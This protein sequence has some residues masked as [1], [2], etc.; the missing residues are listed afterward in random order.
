MAKLTLGLWARRSL[1]RALGGLLGGLDG[2]RIQRIGCELSGAHPVGPEPLEPG[3]AR[4]EGPAEGDIDV[5]DVEHSVTEGDLIDGEVVAVE[6]GVRADRV[7]EVGRSRHPV[8]AGA[9]G[10]GVAAGIHAVEKVAAFGR[11]VNGID[12]GLE[13]LH[14]IAV[15]EV[16]VTELAGVKPAE[17]GGVAD[18]VF[19]LGEGTRRAPH[20]ERLDA[21]KD[22]GVDD[23]LGAGGADAVR[24]GG[25]E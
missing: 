23:D 5:A 11:H 13:D 7:V 4:V 17:R 21:A 16:G 9:H 10:V 25:G 1:G 14:D 3:Q 18:E 8:A 15:V 22:G 2:R 19:A 6:Q 12:G 24:S 20:G